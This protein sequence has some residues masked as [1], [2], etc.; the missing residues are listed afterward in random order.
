[1]HW[2]VSTDQRHGHTKAICNEKFF[3]KEGHIVLGCVEKHKSSECTGGENKCIN[4][5][6]RRKSDVIPRATGQCCP[7][8]E[9]EV[10]WIRDLMDHGY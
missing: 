5:E 7:F 9:S 8:L 3:N 2:H 4:C 6:R 1:M 10:C